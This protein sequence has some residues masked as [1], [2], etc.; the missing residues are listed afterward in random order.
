MCQ[1]P[2]YA[3]AWIKG[4]LP[5]FGNGIVASFGCHCNNCDITCT[6]LRSSFGLLYMIASS[7]GHTISAVETIDV[8]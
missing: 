6:L 7:R 4:T 1:L 5:L 2:P 8:V 3:M